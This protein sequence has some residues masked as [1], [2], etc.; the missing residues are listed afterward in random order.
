MSYNFAAKERNTDDDFIGEFVA[1]WWLF[2]SLKLNLG[3][4][5]RK[6]VFEVAT[7]VTRQRIRG[8]GLL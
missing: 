3:G 1:L 8:H 6:N 2:S 4:F 5:K 7:V